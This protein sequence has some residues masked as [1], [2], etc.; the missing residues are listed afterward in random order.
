MHLQRGAQRK[1]DVLP[2]KAVL[3]HRHDRK[4]N[5][6]YACNAIVLLNTTTNVLDKLD[7]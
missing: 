4:T 2:D 5:L 7:I 1:S 6:H 3:I